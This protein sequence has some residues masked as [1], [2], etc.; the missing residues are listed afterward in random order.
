[1]GKSTLIEAIAIYLG[2]NAEGGIKHYNFSS[3]ETH[4]DLHAHIKI[5]KGFRRLKDGFF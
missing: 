4:S 2:F 1:M 5:T 3:K